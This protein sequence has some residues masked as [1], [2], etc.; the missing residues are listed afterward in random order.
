M[1]FPPKYKFFIPCEFTISLIVLYNINTNKSTTILAFNC[2]FI[3]FYNTIYKGGFF[4]MQSYIHTGLY[5]YNAMQYSIYVLL[6]RYYPL[7]RISTLNTTADGRC[8]FCLKVGNS[9]GSKKILIVASCHGREYINSMLVMNQLKTLLEEQPPEL[10]TDCEVYIIPMLNPDGVSISQFGIDAIHHKDIKLLVKNILDTNVIHHRYWKSNALGVD[11]NRNFPTKSWCNFNDN[12]YT[13]SYKFFKGFDSN[14]EVE[15]KAIT[16]LCS[17]LKGLKMVVSYHSSGEEVYFNYGQSG[18]LWNDTIK[19]LDAIQYQT[20]YSRAVPS[21]DGLG[22]SDWVVNCLNIPAITL[23]TGIGD[24][25]LSI[26]E[27]PKIWRDNKDVLST[28]ISI[29]A[30]EL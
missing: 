6:K 28:L 29:T 19:I 11:I 3:D 13:P 26:N 12:V 21:I 5:S 23:E 20:R 30:K 16:E 9:K 18:Q 1:I 27:Y 17:T 4:I 15:T 22:C 8:I 10:L 7:L 14:S 24:C 25:P 2:Y